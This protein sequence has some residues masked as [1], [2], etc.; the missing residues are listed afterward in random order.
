MLTLTDSDIPLRLLQIP[1]APKALYVD[2]PLSELLEKPCVAIVGSRKLTPYGRQTTQE[3]ARGLAAAGVV[4]VSGLAFGVDSIAHKA[5]L[6]AGGMTIAVL[7]SPL[8]SVY[9]VS[10]RVLAREIL[11]RGGALVSEY[12]AGTAI[13][14]HNFIGRNRLISGLAEATLITEAALK[15]GSLHTARFA[16]EQGKDVLAVP[17]PIT[18][19]T[20]VGT[21]NLIKTGAT[22]VTELA[23]IFHVLHI[24]STERAATPTGDTAAEQTILDLL[25]TGVTDGAELEAK[26]ALDP[27][28][29]SQSLTML[30]IT[31]KIHSLGANRWS[32]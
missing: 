22:P 25:A 26:A 31:S 23:D 20:S 4:I 9:P 1:T 8:E 14:A 18:S 28:L 32:L 10:H 16:L 27:Q 19:P 29:F 30:E 17:G 13:M 12:P 21:N 5:A 7:P 15:S 2:G 3:L 6:E 24:E 11:E